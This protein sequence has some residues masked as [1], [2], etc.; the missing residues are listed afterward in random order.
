MMYESL[1]R[2]VFQRHLLSQV[3]FSYY[4]YVKDRPNK[5]LENDEDTKW[6]DHRNY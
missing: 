5:S 6:Q 2:T 3:K 1:R 4:T